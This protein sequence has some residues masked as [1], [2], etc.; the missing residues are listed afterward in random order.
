M[1][2][3]TIIVADWSSRCSA[4]GG[5]ASPSELTHIHGGPHA[6]PMQYEDSSLDKTNGCGATFINIASAR[7]SGVTEG[8]LRRM[9]PDLKVSF[10]SEN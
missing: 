5:N 2:N 10:D 8:M 6:N 9:R 4:C 1:S 7:Y 3:A